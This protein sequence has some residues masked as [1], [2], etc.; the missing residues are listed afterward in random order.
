MP[1]RNQQQQGQSPAQPSSDPVGSKGGSVHSH[2]KDPRFSWSYV[3]SFL[4]LAQ[5]PK[6]GAPCSLKSQLQLRAWDI[7]NCDRRESGGRNREAALDRTHG[8]GSKFQ[9]PTLS[10]PNFWG[11]WQDAPIPHPRLWALITPETYL[12]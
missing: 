11:R 2:P 9:M 4:N 5:I 1:G 12:P 6:H 3:A 7:E 8:K 10:A